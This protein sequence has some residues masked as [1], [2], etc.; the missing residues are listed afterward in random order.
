MAGY[1][2][3]SGYPVHLFNRTDENL[4][5]VR[6]HKGIEVEGAMT[7]FG[8]VLKATSN[9]GEAVSNVDLIMIVT[10]STAHE[11]LAH[12]IAP[13]LGPEQIIILNPGRTG[14][15]LAFQQVLKSHK[16]KKEI[17]I[18]ETSTFLYASRAVSRSRAHIFRIKNKVSLAT[19][20]AYWIPQV[21]KVLQGPFP[22]FVAGSN[23]LATSMENIGAI[24]HPALTLLNAG[25]IEATQGDFDY[26]IQGIT[27][28]VARILE[29]VD[30]DRLAVAQSLGIQAVSAREWLYLSYDSQGKSLY[31]AIQNTE[32]YRG[33]SAP[34]SISHRYIF[35]DVPMS[36][37]PLASLG[38]LLHVN[39]PMINLIIQLAS[40]AHGKDYWAEGR[41]VEKMGLQGMSLKQ[42]RQFVLGSGSSKKSSSLKQTSSKRTTS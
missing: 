15:A 4:H 31:E 34:P 33:I 5:A 20:P 38:N 6:W 12:Q 41:T 14:G 19:L 26:Y 36:L 1:L 32:S 27:P 7:G 10:P 28:T 8:P 23:V 42:I 30:A 2:G 17:L 9:L 18:G 39:T 24:F 22:E 35:E 16:I 29:G 13:H 3:F 25:W 37:V 11:S 21:L 40:A